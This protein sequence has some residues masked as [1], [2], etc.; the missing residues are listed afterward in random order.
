M[1]KIEW[2]DRTWN[3]TTGCNKI[4]RGC[5]NCYAEVM[6]RRLAA[7]GQ[8]KYQKPFSAGVVTH[9]DTLREPFT[10]RKPSMVFVNSMSDLF[11][12][13]VP[14]S[15]IKEVFI[16][17]EMTPHHTYQV[18][19][20]RPARMAL[21]F[22]SLGSR[23]KSLPNVWLGTSVENQEQSEKR[24]PFLLACPAAVH[25][26][27]CE[28]LVG[29]VNFRD[30]WLPTK[31]GISIRSSAI[32]RWVIAGG[33]SGAKAEPMHPDWVRSLR[34]QCQQSGIPFFF[35]QWGGRNKKAAG[36]LL[37]GRQHLE[38]PEPSNI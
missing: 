24:I 37:D 36:N 38:F 32:I 15:F 11:H 1:S 14:F 7:M 2:T 26:L 4:S 9:N 12:K 30:V 21:F 25:F 8:P 6:H 18:L 22:H 29:P 33:E 31:I 17:M 16:T 27:S 3:P 28:P 20:K 13:D 23:Y 19:T 10:W 5:K 34:D 35:K